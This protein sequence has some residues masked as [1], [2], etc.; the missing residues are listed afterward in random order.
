MSRRNNMAQKMIVKLLQATPDADRLVASCAR[1]CYSVHP[2]HKLYESMTDEDILK[3]LNMTHGS[4]LEHAVYTFSVSGVSRNLTHQLVRHRVGASFS[5]QSQRYVNI[6]KTWENL[7]IPESVQEIIDYED[8]LGETHKDDIVMRAIED[9]KKST[10]NLIDELDRHKVPSEDL[11][12]FIASG[13]ASNITITMNARELIHFCN[14]RMCKRAQKE[15]RELATEMARLATEASPRLFKVFPLESQCVK[16]RMCEEH[17][18]CG[19]FP[20][21]VEIA[22]YYYENH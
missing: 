12:Y 6:H 17:K 5:Q 3:T 16:S 8:M 13:C 10:Q 20:T 11:R 2:A 9:C 15:I 18:P 14:L 4:T 7:V 22:D 1:G 21:K 19:R